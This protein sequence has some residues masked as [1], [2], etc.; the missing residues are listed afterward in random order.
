MVEGV[1]EDL[2]MPRMRMVVSI[3]Y[4][5]DTR[6]GTISGGKTH[7]RDHMDLITFE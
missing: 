2:R 6:G 7:E 4:G 5:A 3:R 1:Q